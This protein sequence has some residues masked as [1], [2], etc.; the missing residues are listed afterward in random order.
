MTGLRRRRRVR[1]AIIWAAVAT[2][3]L[4][5]HGTAGAVPHPPPRTPALVDR[6]DDCGPWVSPNIGNPLGVLV[7]E[8]VHR[9]VCDAVRQQPPEPPAGREDAP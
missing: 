3:I 9:A 8:A 6:G 4:G 5:S 1:H 7:G 2:G